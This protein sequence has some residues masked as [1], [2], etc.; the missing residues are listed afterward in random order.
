M[1]YI[2]QDRR[3]AMAAG[4]ELPSRTRGA[5]LCADLSGFT[6]LTEA[7]ARKLGKRR[8]A[9]ELTLH[10]NRFYEALIAPVEV[11]G[12]SVVGFSGDAIV[13]WFDLDDGRRAVAAAQ[14][15]RVAMQAFACLQLSTGETISLG[16]K[17]AVASGPVRRLLVGDPAIQ[18]WDTLAGAVM[19]RLAT[20]GHLA[21]TGELLLDEPAETQLHE[22]LQITEWRAEAGC[23]AAVLGNANIPVEPS[24]QV[25]PFPAL[26]EEQIRPWL[27]PAVFA[28]LQ[29]GRGE[30]L[31]E[32]RPAAALFL[33]FAGLDYDN[34]E[35]VGDKLDVVIRH[36]QNILVKYDGALIQLT[37]GDKGSYLYAAFGAPVAHEDDAAR[38]AAAA[39]ELS[40][41][42]G[43]VESIRSVSIGLSKGVMRAG[44]YGSAAC[45]TYGVLG[46]QVNL[47]AR[48]M[49]HA[50]P[51]QVLA[52]E[53][54]WQATPDFCW[55]ALPALEVKGKRAA[56]KPAVLL[57]RQE[58]KT[59]C[60]PALPMVGRVAELALIEEKLALARRG[61]GQIVSITGEAGLGKSRLLAEVLQRADNLTRY[62]GECQSYGTQSAYLVWH[63][64][65]RA[66]FGLAPTGSPAEQIATLEKAL[67]GIDSDFPLR[68]P[69]LG[70]AL[71]LSIP[72]NGL[73]GA[74]DAKARKT[75]RESLLVDCL[76]AGAGDRPLIL[77]LEDAHWIDPLSRDLLELI[78]RAIKELPVLILLAYRPPLEA[79]APFA[80]GI[81]SLEYATEVRLVELTRAE[82]EQL[83]AARLAHFGLPLSD[84][85]PTLGDGLPTIAPLVA[86]LLARAQ[87]NPFY[88]EELLNYLHDKD[89]DPR[90]EDA[91]QHADLPDSLHS[92][93]LSR[94][95]QLSERQQIT[96]KAASV[97]GRLF[98]AAWLYEYYPPLGGP[99]QVC[100][101]LEYLSRLEFTLLETP[102]PEL[103]YLFKHVITQEV[104]YESLAY[105]TRATLH[106]Q[107]ACYLDQAAGEDAQLYLD[108]L[109][110]HYERSDN[111]LKKREYLRKA[112]EAA[113]KA[114]ANEA[115]LSYLGRALALAP[116]SDYAERFDILIAREKVYAILGNQEADNQDVI[117]LSA[118]AES[119]DDNG[120]RAQAAVRRSSYA[121]ETSNF[122]A[123]IAAAQQAVAFAR[124]A[125]ADEH[126]TR[127]YWLWGNALFSQGDY[128]E[129]RAQLEQALA[130]AQA[131]KLTRLTANSLMTLGYL[132]VL[133]AHY[134]SAQTYLE[135]ALQL[136]REV[137]NRIG[138]T[139]V[140]A[141][142]T[143]IAFICG[144]LA[145]AQAYCE[146]VLYSWHSIDYRLNEGRTFGSLGRLMIE[147]RGDYAKA[148]LYAEQ[149][150]RLAQESGDRLGEMAVF[151]TFSV[152]DFA[153]NHYFAARIQ[154]EQGLRTSREIGVK[155]Y[156][157]AC[158]TQLGTIADELGEYASAVEYDDQGISILRE[159]G[160]RD[161]MCQALAALG[162]VFYHAG[163]YETAKN[164]SQQA[165]AIAQETKNKWLQTRALIS[166]G[167][168]LRGLGD[169]DGAA[170]AYRQALALAQELG[171]PDFYAKQ[172]QTGL[173]AIALAQGNQAE[174]QAPMNEILHYLETHPLS[175]MD[176]AAWSY[177]TCYRIL[178]ANNDPRARPILETAHHFLQEIAAGIDDES[179]RASFL[180]NARCNREIAQAWENL[181]APQ[182]TTTPNLTPPIFRRTGHYQE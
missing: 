143:D 36:V 49:Q 97:I 149:A 135:R 52:S 100:A 65:W 66:F 19:D 117:A 110:Y 141:H 34:D 177:L 99:A 115:A 27:L 46:D 10:L 7:L 45:R 162:M 56:V 112:G 89:L 13:C 14:A 44:A 123:A 40:A 42:P 4:S 90:R 67:S 180:Q 43:E 170:D 169:L 5:A 24:A 91:W 121:Q 61:Q 82:I 29:A 181:S 95:D 32:L 63:S 92:L 41:L 18:I 136:Q 108:L 15:M 145:N 48:L 12:G 126:E 150:L 103:A 124:L 79:E 2:P 75:S 147:Q 155:S 164:Q 77:A 1:A 160:D 25:S 101:D 3:Q 80:P 133:T 11:Y 130:L 125:G 172:A 37:I 111:L 142:L 87:G 54:V 114:Y 118:L 20:L 23:R 51:G 71:N 171:L 161:G 98:R 132:D 106:E 151:Y 107:F 74:M 60:A 6:P 168:A 88:T 182:A 139:L 17:I 30:F 62:E 84:G 94:I 166:L 127:G 157:A 119:L 53:S 137:G 140:L 116:E 128:A 105:A 178:Q 156:E 9:E 59:S 68:L 31:T 35:Q 76:R 154:A 16:V 22:M 57:G 165:F 78:G 109:A 167:H 96:L 50:A 93:I 104:A 146:R 163:Q 173:V 122:P 144:N 152:I 148:R 28:R 174:A 70:A 134:D 158:L 58:Q 175:T 33:C 64:I 69:L 38:A 179:L 73:T 131:A 8:G 138:E 72:D 86:R 85:I 47:A 129:A 176:E 102:E 26:S 159:I 120:R 153:Q 39:L 81:A 21:K 83:V 55:Q 113:Q